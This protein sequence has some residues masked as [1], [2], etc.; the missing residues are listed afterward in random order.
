MELQREYGAR[1]L[2]VVLATETLGF[3]GNQFNLTPPQEVEKSHVYYVEHHHITAPVAFFIPPHPLVFGVVIPEADRN[4]NETAYH[5]SELPEIVL[6]DKQ[7]IIRDVGRGWD[8]WTA[9]RVRERVAE[10][11]Q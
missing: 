3:V 5:V 2:Q 6:I 4:P 1:D 7:G 10:L 8:A 11:V 9:A